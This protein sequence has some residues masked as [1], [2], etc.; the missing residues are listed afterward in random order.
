MHAHR[1]YAA[2]AFLALVAGCGVGAPQFPTFTDTA[3][4]LDGAVTAL[5]AS[6]PIS[7]YRDGQK[8]RVVTT[9][10]N[11][12]GT[13]VVFDQTTHVAYA[14]NANLPNQLA[15]NGAAASQS[16]PIS[17]TGAVQAPAGGF[18]VRVSDADAPQ[19]LEASWKAL[20]KDG[21]VSVGACTAAGVSGHAWRPRA[22]SPG[23]ERTACI[24]DDG[25][26]LRLQEGARTLFEANAVQR[27]P[28][29][30]ALFG[31]PP[32]YQV[33][34]PTASAAAIGATMNGLDSSAGPSPQAIGVSQ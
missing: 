12:T 10:A 15:T 19:P 11:G 27:G 28:Q 14:L 25:I 32:G 20:G 31:V 26:V 1:F 21:V 8:M 17:Q 3:Y 23:A 30:A 33:I 18:A 16:M 29:S 6:T 5:G 7:I 34:T 13:I 2:T 22:A 24:T 4:R 9:A